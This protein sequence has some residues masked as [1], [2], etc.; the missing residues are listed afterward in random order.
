MV[1]P[2]DNLGLGGGQ[3][4][5]SPLGGPSLEAE[6]KAMRKGKGRMLAAM[7]LAVVAA[8]A[9]AI[10]FLASGGEAE[11]YRTFGRNINGLKQEHFD[12]FWG[13]ALRGENVSDIT[14]NAALMSQI[15]RRALQGGDRYVAQV[16]DECLGK[17]GDLRPKLVALIPPE[18]MAQDVDQL[19]EATSQLQSAWS[20]FISHVETAESYSSEAAE[21]P[22]TQ[23]ARGWYDFKRIHSGLN[24]KIREKIGE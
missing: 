21:A 11:A 4:P 2:N 5:M 17:L 14:D 22:I 7:I 20:N 24:S 12:Q 16:R 13:C 9:L 19:A 6:E 1:D 10:L 18:G 15:D 8:L 3:P 23:I